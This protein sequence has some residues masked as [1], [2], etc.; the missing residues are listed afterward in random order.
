[1][2]EPESSGAGAASDQVDDPER[3]Y[4]ELRL[5]VERRHEAAA[6]LDDDDPELAPAVERLVEAADELLAFE[7]RLPVLRD[8]PARVLSV[9]VLQAGALAALLGGV[10]LGLGVWRGVLAGGWIPFVLITVVASLRMATLPVASGVGEHRRQRYVAAVCGATGLLIGPA[11]AVAGW[12]VG[13]AVAAVHVLGLAVL[14]ELLQLRKDKK[15]KKD[16]HDR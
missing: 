13:L 1:V 12:L 14:L 3:R 9:Q 5:C 4:R 15:D 10:L 16:K 8:L 2:S 7:D 6:A 11:A